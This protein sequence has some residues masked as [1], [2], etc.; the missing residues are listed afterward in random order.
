M[1]YLP[2]VRKRKDHFDTVA[3]SGFNDVVETFESFRA[4]VKDPLRGVPYL[5]VV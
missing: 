2:I 4:I 5:R 3:A 1:E